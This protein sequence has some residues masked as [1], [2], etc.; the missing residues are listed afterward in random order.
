MNLNKNRC[1]T[2][3]V[4]PA[5]LDRP[6]YTAG[7]SWCW[8]FSLGFPQDGSHGSSNTSISAIPDD[9]FRR[10]ERDSDQD[11]SQITLKALSQAA[12]QMP[13][14]QAFQLPPLCADT[15]TPA[16]IS[17]GCCTVKDISKGYM[18]WRRERSFFGTPFTGIGL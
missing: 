15:I 8:L 5:L 7:S 1:Q 3:P 4:H 17:S 10:T 16:T 6:C 13:D 18:T 12:E 2:F 11:S 9:L 14:P